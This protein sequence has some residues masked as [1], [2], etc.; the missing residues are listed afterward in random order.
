[1]AIYT[2]FVVHTAIRNYGAFDELLR[3]GCLIG[4]EGPKLSFKINWYQGS[5]G[6]VVTLF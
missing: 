3:F 6:I 5:F 4:G 1:M 2:Y